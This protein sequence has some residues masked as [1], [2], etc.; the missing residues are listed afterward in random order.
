MISE[1]L[2]KGSI[3][4]IALGHYPAQMCHFF[5]KSIVFGSLVAGFDA[6]KNRDFTTYNGGGRAFKVYSYDGKHQQSIGHA[7]NRLERARDRNPRNHDSIKPPKSAD[8]WTISG[9]FLVDMCVEF[10]NVVF[11]KFEAMA[12]PVGCQNGDIWCSELAQSVSG[13]IW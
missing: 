6:S 4:K 13:I 3:H 11:R 12:L 2:Q 8:P 5:E 9:T 1:R 10:E 7:R